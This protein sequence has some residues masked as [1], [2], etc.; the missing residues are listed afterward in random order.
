MRLTALAND[1]TATFDPT[2]SEAIEMY[3]SRDAARTAMWRQTF[4]TCVGIE[5]VQ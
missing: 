1:E 2:L 3:E 4:G 5:K